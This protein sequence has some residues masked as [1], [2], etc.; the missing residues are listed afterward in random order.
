MA[1]RGPATVPALAAAVLA[2]ALASACGSD[3]GT[4]PDGPRVLAISAN[5]RSFPAP[6]PDDVLAAVDL[7]TGA[8][9]R[10]M[11][12]AE[13]WSVL[14]PSAGRFN[15][16]DFA[17]RVGLFSDRGLTILVGI[18][19]V[20]TTVKE[21]PPDLGGVAFDSPEMKNR[22]HALIDA[23]VPILAGRVAFL[24]IGNEVD[25]YLAATGEGDAYREFYEDAVNYTHGALPRVSVGVTA[26]YGGGVAGPAAPLVK[27]LNAASDA[28]ILTYYPLATNFHVL[29]P[30]DVETALPAMVAA[31][32]GKRVVVQEL[33]YPESRL[34]G[35]SRQLQADFI[36]RALYTWQAQGGRIP[37]LNVF[38]LHD[39]AEESCAG[40]AS[41]YGLAGSA[42][43]EA[44]VCSLGLRQGDGTPKLAWQALVDAAAQT[45]LPQ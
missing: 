22:F 39:L 27:A 2:A 42:E 31:A 41:Y 28:W 45:G 1:G 12:L 20:N 11:F 5:P 36:S 21:T 34:L 18:Q 33:G 29:L 25:V 4:S 32:G 44:Y 24:S 7:A 16:G 15:L 8:G 40:L 23:L 17:R 43:F 19:V 38:L 3:K 30:G 13:R 14:E 10:G 35:G 26:T 9:A 37:F 6:T